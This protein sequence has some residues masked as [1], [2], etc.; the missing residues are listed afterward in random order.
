MV[1]EEVQMPP[2]ELFEIM[3]L[4]ELATLRA[5]KLGTSIG[6]DSYVEFMGRLVGIEP[7]IDD[8]PGLLQTKA[9]SQDIL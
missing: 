2:G 4:T 7:L 8:L 1:L 9:K 6:T 3:S 5:R